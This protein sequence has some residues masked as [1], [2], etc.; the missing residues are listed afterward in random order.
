MVQIWFV[1]ALLCLINKKCYI[2][3]EYIELF[4]NRKRID[5]ANN[6][7]SPVEFENFMAKENMLRKE[8]VA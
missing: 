5:S 8:I 1:L 2:D 7:L 4:Y 6:N 3:D